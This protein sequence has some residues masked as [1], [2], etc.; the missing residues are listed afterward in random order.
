MNAR[1]GVPIGWELGKAE[2]ERIRAEEVEIC[3][4]PEAILALHN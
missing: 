4:P 3:L 1:G 2:W